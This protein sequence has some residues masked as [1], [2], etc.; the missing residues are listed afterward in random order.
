MAKK[1]TEKLPFGA[2]HRHGFVRVAAA[3]PRAS[4]GDVAF[5]VAETLMLAKEADK[6]GVDL[7]VFPEL[8]LSSYAIDDLLLQDAFL[9]AVEAGIGR[10]AKESAKLRTVLVVGAPL[11]RGGRLYNCGLAI[12][13]GRI[14]GAVPKSFLPNYREYYEKRWFASGVGLDGLKMN[15][16]GQ[17]VPFGPDLIFA[18]DDLADFVFHIEICEDY[19]APQPPST[20]GAMAGALILTNLSAS[21]ITIG[22][23]DER[24][25]LCASQAS[26]C[27]AGY[28]FSASG[29]GEST[30]DLAWDGQGSIYELGELLAETGRFD[31]T[32]ELALADID[33]QRLRLE[34]MRNGTFNDNARAAGH[35]E[36]RFR[37]IGFDHRPDMADIGFARKLR[38][39]PY[40]PNRPEQLDQDCY[41]AFNIQVQGLRRRFQAT[42]GK[43]L[44]IGVSGGLDS[45]HALIV[46]A[47][48]CDD[49]ELPR[50]TI[51]GFTMPGF[52]T[53]AETKGNAWSLMNALGIV[54]EEIDIRPAAE[55]MLADLGHPFAKGEPVYD[56]TFENVQA[57]LRTDYLFRLANQRGGFVVGTG[58]LSEIALGWSTY[59]VGD[60]M[61]HYGVNAGVPKTLI[62]YLIRWAIRSGQFED[63]A[64][65][66]L[67]AIL[68]TKISPELV[69]ADAKSGMQSTEERIGPYELHDFFLYHILRHGQPPSKVAFMAW[70]AWQDAKAG[71]WPLD[72]PD[73]LKREYDLATIRKWLEVFCFR[74]FQLS[75]YKRSATPNAPKVSGGGALSP[76][77][78]WRAPSDG[79]AAPW[80]E[81]LKAAFGE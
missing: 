64:N 48:A 45:T 24:K 19:W 41:E 57:G 65:R 13:R 49:L 62:Q 6:K 59:G 9:D 36:T 23:A 1:K 20:L 76:R 30:T 44:V 8:N 52:A 51:L 43:H 11:R 47:R 56:V 66:V 14:L 61:S 40:V 74:F 63:S 16:A 42:S 69:P 34:R 25:L 29:P 72:Y 32:S 21:N 28:V 50:S 68:D 17:A 15:V 78:D 31:W 10:L 54:G 71:L 18:A 60:Q 75:Q 12:A 5:N 35:P 79:N 70:Q 27:I 33:V 53:G 58:D 81:E 26:R 38:R 2:I 22:K 39:F 3:S 77:G 7:A 46:A 67:Q 4:T 55:R 73:A 37:R 80:L